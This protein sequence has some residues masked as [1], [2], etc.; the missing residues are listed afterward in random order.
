M[1]ATLTHSDS[2]NIMIRFPCGVC[3]TGDVM[4]G[5]IGKMVSGYKRDGNK[6]NGKKMSHD[7]PNYTPPPA[8]PPEFYMQLLNLPACKISGKCDNC[9]RCSR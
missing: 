5:E 6:S 1:Q 2:G 9:G 4:I 7:A 3:R 8:L